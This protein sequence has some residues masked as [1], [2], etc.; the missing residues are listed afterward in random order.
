MKRHD[1]ASHAPGT[2]ARIHFT[3]FVLAARCITRTAVRCDIT[4]E[5]IEGSNHRKWR[6]RGSGKRPGGFLSS[7]FKP[8]YCGTQLIGDSIS[9]H[10][11]PRAGPLNCRVQ[12]SR[13]LRLISWDSRCRE[14]GTY[15]ILARTGEIG[16]HLRAIDVF[17]LD[18]GRT[19]DSTVVQ[20]LY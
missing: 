12:L 10:V 20:P 17:Y 1:G 13:A 19:C 18:G 3:G 6:E 8:R 9:R 11:F 14:R 2:P 16:A 15:R 5:I 7:D 4:W